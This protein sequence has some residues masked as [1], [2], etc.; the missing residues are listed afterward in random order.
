MHTGCNCDHGYGYNGYSLVQLLVF[1]Q[2]Q[3]LDLQ[4]LVYHGAIYPAFI[5]LLLPD[6]TIA[7]G[8]SIPHPEARGIFHSQLEAPLL[9]L[10][11]T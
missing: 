2:F 7:L 5:A 10:R 9:A 3:W 4:A 1:F 11:G 8:F 6:S